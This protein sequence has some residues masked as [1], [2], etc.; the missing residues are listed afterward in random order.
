M[1]T[2]FFVMLFFILLILFTKKSH[3]LRETARN[4]SFLVKTIISKF[5]DAL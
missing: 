1:N 5:F 2:W 3:K 4:D